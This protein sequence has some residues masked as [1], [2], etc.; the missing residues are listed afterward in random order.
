MVVA[1]VSSLAKSMNSGVGVL[2]DMMMGTTGAFRGWSGIEAD[3]PCD[4]DLC[5]QSRVTLDISKHDD[6]GLAQDLRVA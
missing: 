2:S 6:A 3:T 5:C 4:D 1:L